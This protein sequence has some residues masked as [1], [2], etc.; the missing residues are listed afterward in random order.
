[1]RLPIKG[2]PR[3]IDATD[4][5]IRQVA[6]LRARAVVSILRVNEMKKLTQRRSMRGSTSRPRSAPSAT[7]GSRVAGKGIDH[8]Q[9]YPVRGRRRDPRVIDQR[10]LHLTYP[11]T[12][13]RRSIP[14]SRP[15]TRFASVS[16]HHRRSEQRPSR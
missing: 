9:R 3:L 2:R 6:A 7:P 4:K 14:C 13:D 1:M 16:T 10:V 15:W 11:L 8:D 12:C 5:K